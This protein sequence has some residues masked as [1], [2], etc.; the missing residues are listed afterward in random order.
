[1][2]PRPTQGKGGRFVGYRPPAEVSEAEPTDALPGS[3][4]K[5]AVLAARVAAGQS[6]HADGDVLDDP[7]HSLTFARRGNRL[8]RSGEQ[9]VRPEVGEP[10]KCLR[11]RKQ[12]RKKCRTAPLR[13]V[14]LVLGEGALDHV[15]AAIRRA[16]LRAGQSHR[17]VEA[18]TGVACGTLSR[19][20][21]GQL[22][23]VGLLVLLALA[24]T[25]GC[26]LDALVG[27]D[28][29]RRPPAC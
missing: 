25:F 3:P 20:E 8:V 29:D 16:R 21:S 5:Q 7:S 9:E 23:D 19:I 6:L 15:G 1:M 24:R 17:S 14:L 28:V 4:A 2:N 26:T 12:N 27:H 13:P 22:R 11:M 10:T 18:A